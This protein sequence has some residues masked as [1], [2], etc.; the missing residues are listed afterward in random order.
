MTSNGVRGGPVCIVDVIHVICVI[1]VI[2]DVIVKLHSGPLP[3]QR[4]AGRVK[5][6]LWK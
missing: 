4:E 2:L 1:C 6:K 3:Q 5:E